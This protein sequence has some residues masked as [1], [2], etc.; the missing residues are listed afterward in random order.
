MSAQVSAY[1]SRLAGVDLHAELKRL[2]YCVC[3]GKNEYLE[4]GK[5]HEIFVNDNYKN[6]YNA[7]DS[8]KPLGYM[9]KNVAITFATRSKSRR[10]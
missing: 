5:N 6:N 8:L 10:Y 1:L 3:P 2:L 7:N 9:N 4:V